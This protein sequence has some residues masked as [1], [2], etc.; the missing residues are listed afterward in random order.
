MKTTIIKNAEGRQLEILVSDYMMRRALGG[1][2]FQY[3]NLKF[4]QSLITK[5]HT[6]I[7]AGSSL[8]MNS[9][10]YSIMFDRV[11]AFDPDPTAC[12]LARRNLVL[13]QVTNVTIHQ[14]AL[15]SSADTK[16]LKFN[17][18]VVGLSSLIL[19][20]GKSKLEVEVIDLDSFKFKKMDFI[21]LDVEGYEIEVVLGAKHTITKYQP[22][23]QA[24]INHLDDPQRL[25]D[26]ILGY[27]DYKVYVNTQARVPNKYMPIK[28]KN[29]RF[30]VPKR[31]WPPSEGFF[32]D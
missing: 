7:D 17:P 25:H 2:P 24:E 31:Y 13:N 10:E 26:L 27:G 11:Y 15:G 16:E 9:I 30:F 14:K 4:V 6:A 22:L 5:G 19:D 3:K 21:K 12:E 23:L 8:G 29:D 1:K 28:G 18:K 32:N 20:S